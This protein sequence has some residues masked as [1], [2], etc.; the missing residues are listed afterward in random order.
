MTPVE[1]GWVTNYQKITVKMKDGTIITGKVNQ[2]ES[3]RVS[4]LFRQS[5][6]N[7]IV[8]SDAEVRGNSGKVVLVNTS[9]IMWVELEAA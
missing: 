1:H 3:S 2:G 4:D 7:Y 6:A 9:E 8:L 5:P